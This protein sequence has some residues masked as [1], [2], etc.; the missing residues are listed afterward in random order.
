MGQLPGPAQQVQG[1]ELQAVEVVLDRAPGVRGV[2]VAEVIGELGARLIIDLVVEM[3]ARAAYGAGLD[4]DGLGLQAL[5]LEVFEV[6]L[7]VLVERVPG[8]GNVAA[9]WADALHSRRI[10]IKEVRCAA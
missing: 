4:V 10:R 3:P 6:G 7:R 1:V 8:T 2:E 9:S 5:E